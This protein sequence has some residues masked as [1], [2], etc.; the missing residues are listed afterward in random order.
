MNRATNIVKTF[1]PAR[2]SR[3]SLLSYLSSLSL[4]LLWCL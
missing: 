2:S 4:Y 3:L 1:I